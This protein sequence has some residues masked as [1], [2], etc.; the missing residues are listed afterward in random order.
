MSRFPG[1]SAGGAN[2]PQI[3]ASPS[4]ASSSL[5]LVARRNMNPPVRE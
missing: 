2:Q 4:S 1:Q 3:R 5:D